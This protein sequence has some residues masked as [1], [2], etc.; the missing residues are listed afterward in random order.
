MGLPAL[1][2][3]PRKLW[4]RLAARHARSFPL[5]RMVYQGTS[6]FGP[7]RQ[8]I[9]N[10]LVISRGI[11][12]SESQIFI[13][14]GFLG[15][16]ALIARTVLTKGDE[17]W[18]EDPCFPPARH[19][20]ELA[21][22]NLIP[23][24]VDEDGMDIPAGIALAPT[25]RL[26][27]V[28][29]AAQFPLGFA[30]SRQ[31]RAQL[32]AWAAEAGAWIVEDDYDSEFN[33]PDRPVPTLKQ[34]DRADRVLH[35]DSFS[36]VLFPGLRLGY[37]VVPTSLV[38]DFERTSALLPLQQS[39]FDQMVVCD[40]ITEGHFGRHL[41]RMRSLYAERKCA[42][43]DALRD[44]L[45]DSIQV[46]DTGNMHVLLRLPPNSDDVVI[47]N[48]ARLQ[49]MA[50]N[51]LSPMG[52][53]ART[54]PGL[55]L[56]FTNIASDAAKDAARRLKSVLSTSALPRDRSRTGERTV[57]LESDTSRGVLTNEI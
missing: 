18:I 6:G 32:M 12:C 26:A 28:T 29:P 7:L 52:V 39:L 36:N 25:A 42:L 10:H 14:P 3:F 8:A 38:D 33:H 23:V 40:F 49:G 53:Q 5:S 19:A 4:S 21:G 45:G 31:R 43:V 24:S 30:L 1:D 37:L 11:P 50:I 57:Q 47:A 22:S 54:G 48:Q 34:L 16:L 41:A 55:L 56:G 17:V 35:V 15:A 20:F 46:A 13:T 51:A 27:L 2:A 44:V 9:A